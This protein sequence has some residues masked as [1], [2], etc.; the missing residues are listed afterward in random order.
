MWTPRR[1]V[2]LACGVV[3]FASSYV[4]YAHTFL[5][6]IDGLPALPDSCRRAIGGAPFQG[7][8]SPR[9]GPSQLEAKITMA[10]GPG[11]EELKRPIR[12]EMH[13]RNMVICAATSSRQTM[14][15]KFTW[16]P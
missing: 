1:I 12:L 2:M 7:E 4:S 13:S 9:S 14:A 15:I 11:C 5:G 6:A 10:F 8:V 3:L 16:P